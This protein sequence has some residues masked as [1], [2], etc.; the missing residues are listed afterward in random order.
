MYSTDSSS[1]LDFMLLLLTSNERDFVSFQTLAKSQRDVSPRMGKVGFFRVFEIEG[2]YLEH[3][4]N[5]IARDAR[6]LPL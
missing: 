2:S 4:G 5:R 3:G 1:S 6:C